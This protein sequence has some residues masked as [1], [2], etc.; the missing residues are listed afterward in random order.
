MARLCTLKDWLEAFYRKQEDDLRFFA[1][2]LTS[3]RASKEVS[4]E[5]NRRLRERR[6]FSSFFK[7]LS[8]HHLS[9]EELEW[10][11]KRMEEILQREEDIRTLLDRLL[12]IFEETE[13]P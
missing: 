12:E 13:N 4:Q 9:L 5:L 10:C 7:T 11:E 6:L 1:E 2:L 8:W 3:P